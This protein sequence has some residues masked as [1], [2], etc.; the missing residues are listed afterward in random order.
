M[1]PSIIDKLMKA[2]VTDISTISPTLIDDTVLGT[3]YTDKAGL[4]KLIDDIADGTTDAESALK[5]A[6]GGG[7]APGVT[8]LI[9]TLTSNKK[10][11]YEYFNIFVHRLSG[12]T[13][14]PTK[15]YDITN[16][17]INTKDKLI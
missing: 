6:I 11:N 12:Q 16:N 1:G 15:V 8:D 17:I 7:T 14:L 10:K 4:D 5:K 13:D 2:T 3:R 9:E